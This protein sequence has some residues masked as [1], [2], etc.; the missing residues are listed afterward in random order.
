MRSLLSSIPAGAGFD[1]RNLLQAIATSWY[2]TITPRRIKTSFKNC[3]MWP[4]D[5]NKID[6]N[7]LRTGKGTA[8]AH[9]T[10]H[11]QTLVARPKPEAVRQMEDVTRSYG[12]ISSSG[13]AVLANSEADTKAA[14]EKL[15]ADKDTAKES[16]KKDADNQQRAES[17]ERE[18][19]IARDRHVRDPIEKV[20]KQVC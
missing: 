13:K 20:E 6:V 12:S 11:M 1:V 5:V 2:V 16:S 9:T 15:Q 19:L 4:L 18:A 10:V 8:A 3:G 17:R 7:R 14:T